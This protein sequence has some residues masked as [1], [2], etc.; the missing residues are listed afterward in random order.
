LEVIPWPDSVY[1]LQLDIILRVN[2]QLL[3]KGIHS[4]QRKQSHPQILWQRG[5]SVKS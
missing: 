4:N 2:P 5:Q 1:W 3:Q